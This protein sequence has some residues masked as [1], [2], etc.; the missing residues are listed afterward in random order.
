MGRWRLGAEARGRRRCNVVGCAMIGGGCPV[1]DGLMVVDD[2]LMVESDG[3]GQRV[4]S[5]LE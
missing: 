1:V 5:T 2:G 3:I 4:S